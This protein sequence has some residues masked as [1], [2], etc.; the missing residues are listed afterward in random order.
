[1][2]HLEQA[3]APVKW[4]SYLWKPQGFLC[5]RGAGIVKIFR[6]ET[7]KAT[8]FLTFTKLGRKRWFVL[9]SEPKLNFE[10]FAKL[11]EHVRDH[12]GLPSVDATSPEAQE[13]PS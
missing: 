10:T 12:G 1:M 6:S 4:P 9:D 13:V 3:P 2:A 7:L 8:A 5:A 11:M